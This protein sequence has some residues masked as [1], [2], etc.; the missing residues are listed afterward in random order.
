MNDSINE[1]N[2][3]QKG[4]KILKNYVFN[5]IYQVFII[6]VPLVT[7]PYVSR[8]LTANGIGAYSYAFSLIT[9]YTLF[10]GLGVT[11][12]AQRE[13][14]KKQQD[15]YNQSKI[16]WELIVLRFFSSIICLVINLL[17]YFLGAYGEYSSYMFVLSINIVAV[18]LDVSFLFQG[19]ERF[20]LIALINAFIKLIGV[21]LIFLIVKKQEDL[22]KYVLINSLIVFFSSFSMWFWVKRYI[23]FIPLKEIHPFRHFK[24]V[25]LLFLPT[26]VI[27]IYTVL[28]K[29]LIGLILKNDAENGYY[30]QAE[31]IV[32]MCVT[33]ITC[34]GTVMMSRNA[35]ELSKGNIDNVKNNVYF[36]VKFVWFLGTPLFA[37][38]ICIS[39]NMNFWFFGDGY[40]PVINLMIAFSPIVLSLG[41]NN[42]FGVQYLITLG[43]D[44]QFTISVIIGAVMNLVLNIILINVIGT[45]GAVISSVVA[46]TV[47]L[48]IQL[49][50]V[51]N[52]FSLKKIIL[53]GWKNVVG[54][55]IMFAVVYFSFR[56]LPS[57][58][59]N[60][61]LIGITGL[62]VYVLCMFALKDE[63]L[64][65]IIRILSNKLFKKNI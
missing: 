61:L 20:G 41:F 22:W 25:L 13:I 4:K 63:L 16:F 53:L 30:E 56:N 34:I 46:E 1:L 12:Y 9:Y 45:I 28:D 47:I 52:D 44:K 18:I 29:T 26:I 10:A 49:Y 3:E 51:R 48:F 43:K 21:V 62:G 2:S 17:L 38:I 60:S 40:E 27:S 64:F 32:K 55:G 35:T 65:K 31:R 39:S 33:I 50:I 6:I 15:R 54:A 11:M 7:A 57:S 59:V 58:I 23:S 24:S 14:A 42:I 5:M 37:G 8:V 19:N 36:A